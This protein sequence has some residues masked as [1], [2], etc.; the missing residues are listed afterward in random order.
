L[1]TAAL[2]QMNYVYM[3]AELAETLWCT[4]IPHT[5]AR[6]RLTLAEVGA[7]GEVEVDFAGATRKE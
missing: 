2:N 5:R 6:A 1:T 4:C 3:Y 7:S